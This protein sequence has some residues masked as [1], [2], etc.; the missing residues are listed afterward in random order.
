MNS[1]IKALLLLAGVTT[2]CNHIST[3]PKDDAPA[4]QPETPTKQFFSTRQGRTITLHPLR[5]TFD[6]PEDMVEWFEKFKNNF[7][8]SREELAMVEH[9]EGEWDTEY[10]L[11]CNA[12]MPFAQC[13]AHVGDEGWG[14]DAVAFSDL[15][16]RVYVLEKKIDDVGR[17]IAEKAAAKVKDITKAPAKVTTEDTT[18]WKRW[19]FAYPRW[20]EDYGATAHVDFRARQFGEY[21]V[22]FA[23]MYT[24]Y[25]SQEARIRAML[26][27]FVWGN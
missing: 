22:V 18:P 13:C 3:A 27:H 14:K 6:V 9:G 12:T 26:E 10:G 21:T 19:A 25:Q 5:A 24:N 17:E 1:C 4:P 7:H 11:V 8:L 2:G 20:Y 16:V 23:F 15:Q